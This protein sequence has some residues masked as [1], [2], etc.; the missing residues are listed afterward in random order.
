M[1]APLKIGI[2]SPARDQVHTLY[3]TSLAA[4]LRHTTALEPQ[5]A[6]D[7]RKALT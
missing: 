3:A 5:Y 6:A 4:M 7:L 1:T 2:A